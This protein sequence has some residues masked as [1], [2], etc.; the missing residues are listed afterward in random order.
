[1]IG[2]LQINKFVLELLKQYVQF[3]IDEGFPPTDK[4]IVLNETTPKSPKPLISFINDGWTLEDLPTFIYKKINQE[5]DYIGP[6]NNNFVR[7]LFS[8]NSSEKLKTFYTG[9][10]QNQHKSYYVS[11]YDKPIGSK[12]SYHQF[13]IA[14][15]HISGS[16]SSYI[17]EKTQYLPAKSMYRKYMLECFDTVDGKFKFKNDKNGDYF[18]VIQFDRDNF[19][20]AIDAG[21]FQMSI[22]PYSSFLTS[23]GTILTS[24]Q[25]QN[26]GKYYTLIDESNDTNE[27]IKQK[28]EIK[29]FYYLVSGSLQDGVHGEYTDDAWGVIYPKKGIVILDGVVLDQSCSLQTSTAQ[30]ES[31]NAYKL[32]LSISSS[33]SELTYTT[34]SLRTITGSWYGRSSERK[35]FETYFCRVL[36]GE[37]NYSSNITYTSGSENQLKYISMAE[38]PKSYITSIGLYNKKRQLVAIGKL[39]NPILKTSAD[40]VNFQVRVRLN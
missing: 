15:A 13:D 26:F 21:N 9:S 5:T 1:M 36:P 2:S 20:D 23:S 14:Y 34:H 33:C 30:T 18:Y 17:E 27:S 31:Y 19:I 24:E 28:E 12:D 37:M 11:V 3:Q 29:D 16:G 25:I 38:N 7:G 10:V 40:Q 6:Y 39:K 22:A 32:F 8:C 35:S 4:I